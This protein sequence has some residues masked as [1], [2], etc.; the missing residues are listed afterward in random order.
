[1]FSG[2]FACR[3]LRSEVTVK[4]RVNRLRGSVWSARFDARQERTTSARERAATCER[5]LE[6]AG[7]L[8]GG[9]TPSG[10]GHP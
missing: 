10:A 7:R 6:R 9:A 2:V 1:M 4:S 8:E 3:A 5:E